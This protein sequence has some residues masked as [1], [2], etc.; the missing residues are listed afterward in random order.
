MNMH[1]RAVIA[2]VFLLCPLGALPAAAE[3]LPK[4]GD[5]LVPLVL[6]APADK[7]EQG[8]LGLAGGTPF[9]LKDLGAPFVL[10]EVI[11]VY[12]PQCHQQA[13]KFGQLF[14]R[15]KRSGLDKRIRM[16]A[17]AAGGTPMEV[18]YLKEQGAYP[19]PVVPDEG[20]VVHKLLAEPKTPFTMIVSREGEVRFA[21]LGVIEDVDGFFA[22]IKRL[23]E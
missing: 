20:Y 5:T 21:H 6:T 8:Y 18:A 22:E 17:V 4:P 7:A 14:K 12:C 15:L 23:V 16:L 9:G 2:L 19:F 10:L 1:L 3:E 13:P 11:G